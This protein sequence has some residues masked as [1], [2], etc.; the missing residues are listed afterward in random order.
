MLFF[1]HYLASE[2][3]DH[4]VVCPAYGISP[5][6]IPGAYL[7]ECLGAVS[8][9]LGVAIR[10]PVLIGLSAGGFG[11]FRAYARKPGRYAGFICMAAY[12]PKDALATIPRNGRVRLIAGGR[13][14]FVV[15][16]TLKRSEAILRKRAPDYASMLIPNEDHFFMLSSEKATKKVLRSWVAELGARRIA[17]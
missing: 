12:P 7:E 16:G 14:G 15:D 9:E 6:H 10:K 8:N 2:F 4:I 3:P 13:E 11:G 17:P 1:A 5:S